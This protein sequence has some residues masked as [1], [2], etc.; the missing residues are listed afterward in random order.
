MHVCLF[1]NEDAGE[2]VSADELRRL[3][4]GA[5]HTV[6]RV[7]HDVAALP[8]CLESGLDCVVAAGGDG[9]VAKAGRTLAGTDIPLAILP[10][11]TANNIAGSLAIDGPPDQLIARWREQQVVRIDVGVVNDGSGERRFLESVGAGLVVSGIAEGSATLSKED[12]A[13]HLREA[14]EMYIDAI[15]RMQPHA[16]AVT[17]D[18]EPIGGDFLLIEV[19]NTPSIG[20][21]IRLAGGVNAGDGTLSVVFARESDRDQLAQYMHA[22]LVGEPA[23]A[24]LRAWPAKTVELKGISGYHVDD[25]VTSSHHTLSIAILP[26]HL[27]VLA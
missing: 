4:T 26:A 10:L 16:L 14:R 19:L 8:H 7:V 13:T 27:A 2:G 12:P 5:G 24:G 17:I 21:G 20:P 9:T 1:C 22:R 6:S 18:G 25:M 15:A 3:I 11:G 23:D